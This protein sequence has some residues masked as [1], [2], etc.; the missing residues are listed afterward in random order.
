MKFAML[1]GSTVLFLTATLASTPLYAATEESGAI[2]RINA[3]T[4][5][6]LGLYKGATSDSKLKDIDRAVVK[7]PLDVLETADEDRFLKVMIDG[8]ILWVRKVQVSILRAVTAG[9]LAQVAAPVLAGV[10]RGGNRGC[11]K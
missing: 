3:I 6:R 1:L 9:C 7:L 8:D 11:T 4:S 10:I 2:V 5:P